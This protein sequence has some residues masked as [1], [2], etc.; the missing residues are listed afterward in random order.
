[1]KKYQ[2]IKNDASN[3]KHALGVIDSILSS[4]SISVREPCYGTLTISKDHTIIIGSTVFH[5]PEHIGLGIRTA[6]EDLKVYMR[7]VIEEH[8]A[9]LEAV[10]TL[11][12]GKY[13][14]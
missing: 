11:L 6:L 10:E 8:N 3:A 7:D 2:Q 12:K 13:N 14:E 5:L 4:G 1:M 9:T